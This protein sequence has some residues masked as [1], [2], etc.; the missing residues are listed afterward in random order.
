M[1]KEIKEHLLHSQET[2]PMILFNEIMDLEIIPIHGP[3]HHFIMPAVLLTCYHNKSEN[4]SFLEERLIEAEERANTVPGANCA[5]CGYCGA[6]AGFG[7]FASILTNN[8]PYSIDSWNKVMTITS[9]ISSDIAKYG[10]PRCCKRNGYLSL[11]AGSQEF[12][13]LFGLSFPVEPPICHHF[14][15][16]KEC[17]KTAC[18][19]YPVKKD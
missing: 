3:I 13:K 2:N 10:G 12:E 1:I 18:L 14:Y 15:R 5:M 19:F 11:L 8:S 9:K 4:R 7:I 16:N 6:A 17:K